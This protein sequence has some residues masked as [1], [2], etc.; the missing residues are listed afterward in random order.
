M[1]TGTN[2]PPA[3]VTNQLWSWG[4]AA[5]G[6]TCLYFISRKSTRTIGWAGALGIQGIWIVYAIVTRQWGFI[7]SAVAYGLMYGKNLLAWRREAGV[8]AR[9]DA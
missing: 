4:L 2:G 6:V 3:N 7:A 8:E 9:T 5:L 1:P